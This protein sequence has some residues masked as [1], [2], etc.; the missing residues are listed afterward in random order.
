VAEPALRALGGK[1]AFVDDASYAVESARV[2]IHM[3][4]GKNLLSWLVERARGSSARPLTDADLEQ[5]LKDLALHGKS[6][7]DPQ[8]LIAAIW[9][10]DRA[11]DAGALM[12][13]A[14]GRNG[15]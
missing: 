14:A 7:C 9:A 3:G 4:A 11:D 8:P 12:P 10:L 1:V 2:S 6:G 5:K 13:L 15:A